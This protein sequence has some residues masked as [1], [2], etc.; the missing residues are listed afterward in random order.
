MSQCPQ[1][2]PT[3]STI[4][5]LALIS[6]GAG[7][8]IATQTIQIWECGQGYF[9]LKVHLHYNKICPDF[10]PLLDAKI[11]FPFTK[12]WLNEYKLLPQCNHTLKAQLHWWSL[13]SQRPQ[14]MPRAP[15]MAAL[16]LKSWGVRQKIPTPSHNKSEHVNNMHKNIWFWWFIYTT[17]RFVISIVTYWM[18]K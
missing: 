15:T 5:A 12:T 2:M 8:N 14:K 13:M 17:A 18:Q 10:I 16:A 3:A 7:Q 4:A 1:K 6:W 9:M 11:M